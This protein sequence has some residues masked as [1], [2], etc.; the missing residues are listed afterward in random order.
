VKLYTCSHCQN[1]LY[2]ENNICLICQHPVGFDSQNLVLHTLT[3]K[4]NILYHD[5]SSPEK[6]YRYCHNATHGTCN[7]LVPAEQEETFCVACAL[8]R[9]IPTLDNA[10]NLK[11]WKRIETAKHRLIYSL[12]RLKL[13]LERK[14]N[15]SSEGLAFDFLENVSQEE[16]VMT[17]HANGTIT[18]N[19]EEA[20]EVERVRHKQDLRERYRTLLGHFRHEI[21]HYY[22]DVLIKNS[23]LLQ[24]YRKL[25]GDER[26]DYGTSLEEYYQ[27]GAPLH[28]NDQFIS[29][30]AAAHSWEDWAETWSHYLHLMDTLETAYA[31][32]MAIKPQKLKV[33]ED[34]QAEVRKDPYGITDF[35]D[36]IKIWLP[37]TFALNSINR[38]MGYED[39]YPFVI[40]APV[41]EKLRFIHA[42]CG[43]RRFKN[44]N[45]RQSNAMIN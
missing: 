3:T 6:G 7:W 42:L 17:G 10:G 32:G 20:N 34:M 1:P 37:L 19:I 22:W 9:I 26:K 24:N 33:V 28:W 39:F 13:P 15:D 41:I 29:P 31:F 11:K 40:S 5:I 36:I 21:G 8:N 38:S 23:S 25:F 43:E 4:D 44:S 16:R 30:Y 18:L 35:D 27:N 2:F 12:L 45:V 14:I